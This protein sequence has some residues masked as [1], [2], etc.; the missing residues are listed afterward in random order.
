MS[1]YAF[2]NCGGG[3]TKC[4]HHYK[5]LKWQ[6]RLS[7]QHDEL[8]AFIFRKKNISMVFRKALEAL[9]RRDLSDSWMNSD[10]HHLHI[11]TTLKWRKHLTQIWNWIFI[12]NFPIVFI[13]SHSRLIELKEQHPHLLIL[14][15][16]WLTLKIQ[17]FVIKNKN[18]RENKITG[19]LWVNTKRH[20]DVIFYILE[21][22]TDFLSLS[23]FHFFFLLSLSL[24]VGAHPCAEF[25]SACN[26]KRALCDVRG[27]CRYL[28]ADT[29][30]RTLHS[31]LHT[32]M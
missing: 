2:K 26:K 13:I 23:C 31:H 9:R 28:T 19:A 12:I 24:T 18:H 5:T 4:F 17:G 32:S 10:N 27:R 21:A 8:W 6:F 20:Q 15:L 7:E 25:E 14:I 30:T 16:T 3:K 29:K 22:P 11:I 1:L